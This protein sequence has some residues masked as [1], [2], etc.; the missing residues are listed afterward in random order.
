M[1]SHPAD[2]QNWRDAMQ[3]IAISASRETPLCGFWR[4]PRRDGGWDALGVWR[5][6]NGDLVGRVNNGPIVLCDE[7]F[8]LNV[9]AWATKHPVSHEQYVHF[10]QYGSWPSDVAEPERK[11]NAEQHVQISEALD[12][13]RR[14][15]EEWLASLPNGIST[16]DEA[17]KAA[18]FADRFHEMEKEASL[19]RER[20]KQPHLKAGREVDGRWM[21]IVDKAG[22]A[23]KW[24]AQ[25]TAG[26][27]KAERDRRMVA[28]MEKSAEGG[29]VNVV[30]LKVKA[31]TRGRSRT[32][33][34][35]KQLHVTDLHALWA[36]YREDPRLLTSPA[37][38]TILRSLAEADIAAG[39]TVP[40]A[41]IR[42]IEVVA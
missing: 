8:E 36:H 31:G 22:A 10:C 33:K 20:E 24:A 2:Y 1:N 6:D 28:A 3:G 7:D 16:Q 18:N 23:K 42:E 40:G 37:L 32:L 17:D 35:Q 11:S 34:R 14:Q 41:T 27:L 12:D 5:D 29:A 26:F 30:D 4:R 21:P 25:L 19:T 39:Q 13:L 38:V 15:A 9:V